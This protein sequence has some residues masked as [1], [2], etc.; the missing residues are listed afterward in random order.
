MT[1]STC[2]SCGADIIWVRTP[3]GNAMP[4]N[5]Q[6]DSLWMIDS[7][8]EG[9]AP[10]AKPVQVRVSHFGTCLATAGWKRA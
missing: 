10:K 9:G 1:I 8:S 4:L 7:D 5:A 6:A 2:R 3:A